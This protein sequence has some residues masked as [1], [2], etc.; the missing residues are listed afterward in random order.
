MSAA[1]KQD[2]DGLFA[3]SG[4]GRALVLFRLVLAFMAMMMLAFVL[5]EGWRT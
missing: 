1:R 3:A 5:V 4:E 2:D